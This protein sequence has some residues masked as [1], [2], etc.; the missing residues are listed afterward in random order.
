MNTDQLAAA[1]QRLP[2]SAL[3]AR[4][5][6]GESAKKS[7]RCPFHEDSDASFSLYVGEGGEERWKCFASCGQGDAIDFL[8][9]HQGLNNGDACREY[10]RLAGLTPPPAALAPFHWPSCVNTLALKDRQN[11]VAWR[12][13]TPDFVAWLHV[14]GLVGLF[15]G[16]IAF[17]V[18]AAGGEVIGCH[19]R[20][21]DN[22]SWRYY[23]TGT[24]AAPFIVGDPARAKTALVFESQWDL[25]A[26][27]NLLGHHVQPLADTAAIAT[28]GASNA[29]LLAGLCTPDAIVQAFG[30][31]DAAGQKWLAEV[32]VHCGCKTFQMVTPSPHKDA[33]DWTRAGATRSEM[34]TAIA[35]ASVVTP[36]EA[37]LHASPSRR[38]SPRLAVPEEPEETPLAAFPLDA[39]PPVMATMV[40]AV[41]RTE[42]VPDIL[43]AVCALGVASAAIGT[44]LEV[45]SGPGRTTRANLYL[46][47][48]AESGSGKS[49]TFRRIAAPLVAYEA[50]LVEDWK[51]K[52]APNVQ[53]KLKVLEREITA[54]EKKA[55]KAADAMERERLLGELAFKVTERDALS[56]ESKMPC[57]IAQDVTT[58]RLA[59]LLQDNREFVFST[60]ADAR[61]LVDNLLGRYNPGQTTDESLYLSA[62][63][64]DFTRVDRQSRETV[65]LY[66]PCVALTWFLQPD[67]LTAMLDERSLSASGFLPRLLMCHTNA[68]PQRIEG[69][70]AALSESVCNQWTLLLTDLLTTFHRADKPHCLTPTPEA[71]KILTDFHNGIV[72]RRTGGGDLADVG[73]FAARYAENAWRLSVV[74]HGAHWGGRAAQEP[75]SA[76]TATN[77][78]RIVNWFVAAQLDI[79]TKGRLAAATK[80]QDEVLEL[81]ETIRERKA[82]SFIT[83]RDVYRAR[84]TTTADA[85]RALLERME[86]EGVL[87]GED[88]VPERGGKTVRHYRAV[89]NSNL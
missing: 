84:I 75:L 85:A 14:Q 66:H 62:Y 20:H 30:Q 53:A 71:L 79:L 55:A 9:R 46:L 48:S 39:L 35:S 5:G 58:E 13:Y 83:A 42:R 89:S 88:S 15:E 49:E 54:H 8:A 63:S 86:V 6:F 11:L 72:D 16:R 81:L 73:A 51:Q 40:A 32:S 50:K 25:L 29:R 44:G 28:R 70:A 12:G 45:A 2:L 74:L 41:A 10:L 82:Q 80:V 37:D 57:L 59:V 43:P 64:G 76:E 18:Q 19:Y 7:A 34:E 60:S 68:T 69:E 65:I 24:H 38:S 21:K 67:K 77:A 1:K 36:T 78:V 87:T 4:L 17:P 26:V 56:R 47:A 3:M 23:P 27:L 52:I 61:K 31:N 33:N 22:H